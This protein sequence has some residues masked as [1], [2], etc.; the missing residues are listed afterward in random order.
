M[1]IILIHCNHFSGP[2][3]YDFSAG[4]WIYSHDGLTLH[5]LL[6]SEISSVFGHTVDFTALSYGGSTDENLSS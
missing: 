3:R 1:I 4:T 5:S 6:S 2:K